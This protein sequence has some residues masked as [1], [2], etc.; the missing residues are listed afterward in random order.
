MPNDS[1]GTPLSR[2]G[3]LLDDLRRAIARLDDA[4]AQPENEYLRDAAIQRFEFSFEL[5]WKAA[6]AP[7]PSSATCRATCRGCSTS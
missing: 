2:A 4:L 3:L 6:Q 5:A 7:E 1:D